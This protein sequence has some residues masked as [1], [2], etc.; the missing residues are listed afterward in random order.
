MFVRVFVV[1]LLAGGIVYVC[2]R[3]YLRGHAELEKVLA[4]YA[5]D[6]L[7]QEAARFLINNM[8][9]KFAY[10]GELLERYDTLFSLYASYV[11]EGG[12]EGDPD[13]VHQ[14][15]DSL[16]QTYGPIDVSRL[17]KRYDNESVTADFLINEIDV[18]FEAWK[19]VPDS[20]ACSFDLFCRYVLPYRVGTE[21]LESTR[22]AM[23]ADFR[24]LRDSSLIPASKIIRPLC[25]ELRRVRL[26]SNSSLLWGYP[27]SISMTNMQ[28]ARR[29]AC[30]HL[31]EYYVNVLRACGL[32]ATIDYVNQWGNRHL[33]HAWVTLLNDSGQVV[34]DALGRDRFKFR[35]KPT[36]IY[37]R[38]YEMQSFD[39]QAR[40]FVPGYLLL[41]NSIDVSHLYFPTH[42][43]QVKGKDDVVQ[44]YKNYPYGV[45]CVFDNRRWQPVDYGPVDSGTFT[46]DNLIGDVC[47]MAGYYDHGAFVPATSPFILTTEGEIRFVEA[48]TEAVESLH[49]TRKYPKFSGVVSFLRALKGGVVEV[50]DDAGFR[51]ARKLMDVRTDAG[52]DVIDLLPER[53]VGLHRYVRVRGISNLAEVTFY[54][55][56]P[57]EA[58]DTE[59]TGTFFGA[60]E[61]DGAN[62]WKKAIDK[63]YNSYFANTPEDENYVAL[64]LGDD[65]PYMVTRVRYV[66]RSDTNF[67][68]P[69]CRYRLDYWDGNRWKTVGEKKADSFS[70]DFEHVP[71]GRL[72]IL[73]CLDGGSEERIFTYE[74]G[75]QCWW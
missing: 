57:G 11:A 42:Q 49:L 1:L 41:R 15:W 20:L 47:Y 7:K 24:A 69:G 55:R 17:Q 3:N 72:Y 73:H 52:Q 74:S 66:P 12:M 19:S 5:G 4:H 29:G 75:K 28:R 38:T 51:T 36:K 63:D 26:F 21:P 71:A 40:D 39:E 32:P 31:C 27:V 25:T 14:C 45:I 61:S 54:G 60:P 62:S 9:D 70:V 6:S 37:R 33:G 43:V 30:M 10:D 2:S 16:L 53:S 68:I 8:Y 22:R 65:N 18:A 35:Y 58:Y 44:T 56:R 46:F 67:I 50:A 64:D 48:K 23:F 59:L 34:F 13:F